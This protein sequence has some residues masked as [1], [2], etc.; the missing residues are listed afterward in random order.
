VSGA[1]RT[2]ATLDRVVRHELVH[3]MMAH[4]APR[5]VST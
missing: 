3:A 4:V 2:P 1:L 5:N